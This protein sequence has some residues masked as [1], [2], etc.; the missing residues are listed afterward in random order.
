MHVHRHTDE[1]TK[2]PAGRSAGDV[3]ANG[4]SQHAQEQRSELV[5][6]SDIYVG[7]DSS[8]ALKQQ[9]GCAPLCVSNGCCQ[10]VIAG[11]IAA[12]RVRLFQET[13]HLVQTVNSNYDDDDVVI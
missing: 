2:S 3:V 7:L 6:R 10:R 13:G 4:V 11:A 1:D 5:I 8:I 9:D 12:S